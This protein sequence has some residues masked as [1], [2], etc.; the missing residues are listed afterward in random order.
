MRVLSAVQMREVDRA[1]IAGGFATGAG[2]MANAARA[3]EACLERDFPRA[4]AG[5]IAILCGGGNNGGDGLVLAA[6]LR[7][8]RVDVLPLL[9]ASPARLRGEAAA[10][11]AALVPPPAALADLA[12]WR[13]R[14]AGVLA[15]ALVVDALFGTGLCRPLEGWLRAV[16]EDLNRGFGG[17]V[18]AL[19]LPSGLGADA[20]GPAEADGAAVVRAAATVTFTAPKPGLY[21]S[22]HAAAAGRI[23]VAPIGT[24]E[25]IVVAAGSRLQVTTAADC[26]PLAA[27]RPPAAFKNSF[28]HVVVLAGALGKSG[29]AVLASTAAL[30]A[31]AGLV[32]AAV[33]REVL[34]IVAAA[35]P[36]LMTE[37][38]PDAAASPAAL[39]A[40]LDALLGR[41]TVLAAG[42]GLGAA[43][44]TRALLE[45]ALA[46]ARRPVVLDADG[47]NA[48]AGR[49]PALRAALAHAAAVLTPHPGEMARLFAVSPTDV[50]ARRPYYVQRLAAETGAIALLKGHRTLIADPEGETRINATGNPGMATAGAGDVLTGIIAGLLAQFP[51]VPRLDTVAAA[52]YLHGLAGDLAARRLG[53]RSLLAGDL[54]A[55]LPAAL[56][57]VA[58]REPV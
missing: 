5:R 15:A 1:T 50:E 55:A 24:P 17:P 6:R 38:L 30:R 53:E 27:P 46:A 49:L 8:R 23:R 52:A 32:T 39:A 33:P 2:L 25:A 41:A 14:R 4:L 43:P 54:I 35:R 58:S 57:R 28:G 19:D 45:A 10:A 47:L 44:P 48:F 29:A 20:C 31:G 26:R 34:P 18:L 56:R 21:L 12:A 3:A 42:P 16:V 51:L 22:H 13:A 9:F 36:E 40:S 37:P 11:Y 7:R